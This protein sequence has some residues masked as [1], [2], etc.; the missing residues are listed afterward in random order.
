MLLWERPNI[1]HSAK[2]FISD[3]KGYRILLPA[4]LLP[5]AVDISAT[6]LVPEDDSLD[7]LAILYFFS[8]LFYPLTF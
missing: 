8:L 1:N 2:N 5:H 7:V 3:M 4:Y 6:F